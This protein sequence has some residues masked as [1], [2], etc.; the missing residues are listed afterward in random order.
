[1][2]RVESES[3]M[4]TTK[5]KLETTRTSI[6]RYILTTTPETIQTII[7]VDTEIERTKRCIHIHI[8]VQVQDALVNRG[9]R[10][11]RRVVGKLVTIAL[12]I[13]KQGQL[14]M[15]ELVARYFTGGAMKDQRTCG[16]TKCRQ[17]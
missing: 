11:D 8:T 14:D 6:D 10:G 5:K 9:D 3:W 1:M 7:I 15:H 16:M 4:Q 2:T 12:D 17:M 13:H